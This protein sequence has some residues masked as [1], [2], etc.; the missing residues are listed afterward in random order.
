MDKKFIETYAERIVTVK[1]QNFKE[2]K[3]SEVPVGTHFIVPMTYIT[4]NYLAISMMAIISSLSNRGFKV[5]LLLHD[6]NM[7]SHDYSKRK[8]LSERNSSVDIY[9]EHTIEEIRSLFAL[10]KANTNNI[11]ILKSSDVWMKLI[12]SKIRFADFFNMLNKIKFSEL[13]HFK[14]VRTIAQHALQRSFDIYIAKYYSELGVENTHNPDFIITSSDRAPFYIYAKD[15]ITSSPT[16]TSQ[17]LKSPAFAITNDTPVLIHN[18]NIPMCGM[19]ASD[20]LSIVSKSKLRSN[21]RK[22]L[23]NNFFKPLT[24]FL[25]SCDVPIGQ[26]HFS[27]QCTNRDIAS[28]M[29]TVLE[30]VAVCMHNTPELRPAN[31]MIN[32]PDKFREIR[33]IISSKKGLKI[34]QYCTGKLTIAEIAKKSGSQISNTSTYIKK[35]RRLGFVSTTSKPKIKFSQII[36]DS[37]SM[38][39]PICS[40]RNQNK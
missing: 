37:S 19:N 28:N 30:S 17:H 14:E 24:M 22:N 16:L 40:I 23:L 18:D 1:Y 5:T 31:L 29:F 2:L 21:D 20:I 9:T 15:L 33:T 26:I 4:P 36:I 34:L 10:L 7:L 32:T 27:T 8:I 25:R 38:A 11:I 3:L 39:E 6:N 12:Y 35:L 13:K